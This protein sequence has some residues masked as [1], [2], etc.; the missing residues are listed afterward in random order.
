MPTLKQRINHLKRKISSKNTEI[1]SHN[2]K[3]EK[4]RKA[5]ET[6]TAEL[7]AANSELTA[8]EGELLTETLIK[9]G[10]VI[11]E[12]RAAV[13]AGLFDKEPVKN[14]VSAS[15]TTEIPKTEQ[16]DIC[17]TPENIV[18]EQEVNNEISDS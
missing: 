13:E 5:I 17:I 16:G 18:T 3:I 6:L 7:T 11:S 10:V 8:L 9:K 1:E 12:V 4:A 14:P 15:K 2:A